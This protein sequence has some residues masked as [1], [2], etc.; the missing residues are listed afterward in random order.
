M[1]DEQV[2]A[3]VAQ[4]RA[5]MDEIDAL[6]QRLE[7]PC[8]GQL[9]DFGDLHQLAGHAR[10]MHRRLENQ[11]EL[12]RALAVRYTDTLTKLELICKVH[13]EEMAAIAAGLALPSEKRS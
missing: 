10:W 7:A 8:E 3:E 13:K 12:L 2:K 11:R 1:T 6:L 4:N 9:V 5:R